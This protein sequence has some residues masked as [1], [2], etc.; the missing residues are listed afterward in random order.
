MLRFSIYSPIQTI[1]MIAIAGYYLFPPI[2]FSLL[3]AVVVVVVV[4]SSC[5]FPSSFVR[6]FIRFFLLLH[7]YDINMDP[8]EYDLIGDFHMFLVRCGAANSND[9]ERRTTPANTRLYE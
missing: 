6:S 7:R 5:I 4:F 3:F 1:S 9:V 2:V 8:F